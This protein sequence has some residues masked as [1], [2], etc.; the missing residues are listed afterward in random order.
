MTRVCKGLHYTMWMQDKML[1]QEELAENICSL[2]KLFESEE[3]NIQFIKIFLQSLSKEWALI[4][5]C[6]MDKFLMVCV[7]LL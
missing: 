3:Q 7:C 4:D 6:R 5:R 2:M 1:P